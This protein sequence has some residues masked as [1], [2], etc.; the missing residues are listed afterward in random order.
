M[1]CLQSDAVLL[2]VRT[3]DTCVCCLTCVQFHIDLCMRMV[4]N[5]ETMCAEVMEG[6]NTVEHAAYRATSKK[7]DTYAEE[8]VSSATSALPEYWAAHTYRYI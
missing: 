6:S 4:G 7:R 8:M 5:L 3:S 1:Q 2:S